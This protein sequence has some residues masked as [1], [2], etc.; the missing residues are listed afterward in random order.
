MQAPCVREAPGGPGIEPK[1]TRATK[2][3]IGTSAS[4]AS[5]VWFT[6]A[7]G[8]LTEVYWPTLDRPQVRDLQ[9]L[10]S[11][12]KTF[13]HDERR[14]MDFRV[15]PLAQDALG[16]RII[17]ADKDGRYSLT[18]EV[19]TDPELSTVLMKV[20]W[21]GDDA[22]DLYLLVAPHLEIGGYDNNG[23]VAQLGDTTLLL[24]NK[25]GTWM[26]VAT[27]A[28]SSGA[29]VGYVGETDGWQDLAAD[30]R[31]DLAYDCAYSGNIALTSRLAVEPGQDFTVAMSFAAHRHGAVTAAM[32]ALGLPFEQLQ[33]RFIDEWQ[34][35]C[36]DLLAL[37]GAAGDG[38]E[39]Y[40]RSRSLLLAHEDK[41]YPGAI[42]AS[43][44]IPWGHTKGDHELGGYHLVWS[45]DMVNSATGLLAAGD[46]ETPLRALIYLAASQLPDGGFYQNFWISGEPYWHGVQ[47]DEVAF[48]IILAWRLHRQNALGQ[49]DPYDMVKRAAAYLIRNGPATPQERWEEAAGYSPSTLASNIAALTCA[50]L[51]MRERGDELAAD[52]VQEYADFLDCH[53]EQWTVTKAGRVHPEISEHYVRI[54]PDDPDDPVPR[55]DLD[56]NLLILANQP[57]GTRYEYPAKDIVDAGFLELVRYGIRRADDPLIEASIEVV[58]HLLKLDT[59][60][61]PVWH[62][63]NHDGYGEGE[64]G[65]PYHGYG[66]GRAWPLLT[67][68]RGHYEY[69]RGN[70]ITDYI[71]AMEAFAHG[72]QLLPEQIWDDDDVPE[73]FLEFGKPTGAAT[74][75]MWAHAEYIK[76][77]RT[78]VDGVVFDLIPAVAERYLDGPREH[79]LEVWKPNRQV[80]SIAPGLP[81]RVQAAEPFR[82]NWSA[83]PH[84]ETAAVEA[85]DSGLGI[86]FVDI[87]PVHWNAGASSI[88]FTMVGADGG[89]ADFEVAVVAR[90]QDH[91][92]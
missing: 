48:P 84:E 9:F 92:S 73:H 7:R 46:T 66:V 31:M 38:G 19:I 53:I 62:R 74:P 54:N 40:R 13:F 4:A 5:H 36:N 17:Q 57:P 88:R 41:L 69:A 26:A 90:S 68:E 10:V 61:G 6:I 34:A 49:F 50:A 82:L 32:Q 42:I 60:A 16:Y 30:Y 21:D 24:A 2:D 58:D 8:V 25:T 83:S 1:W 56:S 52:F 80:Q 51:F 35:R 20:S 15:E 3:A 43:L 63:Y 22:H 44:S 67:G 87:P 71:E 29:S 64:D 45:R 12:G 86:F 33:H 81:L 47:L 18:K 27:S 78:R 79:A 65:S 39:L 75:L 59:D 76:L 72:T 85:S 11:D 77:L 14:D 37:G 55:E 89:E 91:S 28:P 70:D 23:E